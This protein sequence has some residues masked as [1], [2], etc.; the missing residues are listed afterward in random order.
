[1]NIID[2][3]PRQ[4]QITETERGHTSAFNFSDHAQ[5][6][7]STARAHPAATAALTGAAVIAGIAAAAIPRM[8]DRSHDSSRSTSAGKTRKSS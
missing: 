6:L 7:A 3:A 1:M 2:A 8:R 4:E 5:K